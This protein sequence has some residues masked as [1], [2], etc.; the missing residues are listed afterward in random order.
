[1]TAH[2]AV[3]L[4][5]IIFAAVTYVAIFNSIAAEIRTA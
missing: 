2:L 3:Q 4:G 5:L 1:M